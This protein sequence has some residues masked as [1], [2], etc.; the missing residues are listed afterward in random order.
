[1]QLGY[2]VTK[3]TEWFVFVV[4]TEYNVT[5][6]SEELIGTTEHFTIYARCRI[7]PCRYNRVPLYLL[8]CLHVFR[9]V[10][11]TPVVPLNTFR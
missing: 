9:V 8:Q 4:L 6:N 11:T 7:N 3:G 5:V 1:M 10:L 2:N